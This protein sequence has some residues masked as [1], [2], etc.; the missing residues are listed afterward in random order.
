MQRDATLDGPA[1]VPQFYHSQTFPYLIGK[2]RDEIRRRLKDVPEALRQRELAPNF[3]ALGETS[4]DAAWQVLRNYLESIERCIAEIVRGHSPSF[5]FHLHRRIRPMLA[6][7][8][9]GKTDDTTVVLVRRIAEL[10]YAKHGDL[11]R[12]DDLGPILR[13]RLETFLDG[14]WYEA[15]AH[16]LGS[17]LK[18]KKLY[19]T[20]KWTKQVVMTNFRVSDLCD[21]FGIEGL[22]YEY[23][24]TSA[25]MRSI[26][27][28]SITKWD[29]TKTPALRYK[30]NVNPLCFDYYDKRNSEARGFE[31]RLGTW[32]DEADVFK[33]TD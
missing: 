26:G 6:E 22:C 5:W 17:K 29:A 15:T 13:T 18:A 11:A 27:K 1:I 30:D 10:A 28:G 31:T 9:E 14:A 21:V 2:W 19:Q 24:W 25:A 12:T 32:I 16:A 4:G 7:F 33:G 20:I 23:W 3:E 8:H